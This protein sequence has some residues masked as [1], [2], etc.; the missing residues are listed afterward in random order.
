MFTPPRRPR[1]FLMADDGSATVEYVIGVLTAATFGLL[2]LSLVNGDWVI[3]K[4]KSVL[5]QALSV[6]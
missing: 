1:E 4:L 2:L 3:G 5:D 6:N